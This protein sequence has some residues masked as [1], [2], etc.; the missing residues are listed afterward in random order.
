ME[1]SFAYWVFHLPNFVLAALIYTLIGR[2]VMSLFIR[3]QSDM[4][5]WV[6]FRQITDPILR[7]VQMVTP[8]VVPPPLVNLFAI[9]W[10]VI[11]RF[12]F[13]YIMRLYGP[14]PATA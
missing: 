11:L 12:A 3:P 6:V 2:Y 7:L 8:A 4:V 1:S 13:F 5:I 9:I 10:L 14:L